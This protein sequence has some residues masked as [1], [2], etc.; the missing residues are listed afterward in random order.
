[1]SRGQH[2]DRRDT[3]TPHPPGE[4]GGSGPMPGGMLGGQREGAG[5]T[6]ATPPPTSA[7]EWPRPQ[8]IA[9]IAELAAVAPILAAA[10]VLALDAEFFQVRARGPDDPTH[11]LSL[12]QIALDQ[13]RVSY[14]VDALRIA[15]LSPLAAPLA[16]GGILKL[17]HGIGADA[18]VLASR[19]LVARD[20]LDLEAVSRSIFGQR[21]SGLQAMLQRASGVRLDKSLQRADW[22]RRPLT[23]AMI[24]Y[25]ARDAE[26]TLV[27][28]AWLAERYPTA[29]ALHRSPAE[30]PPP[31]VAA[32]ILPY[33]EGAR[34]RPVV[35]AVAEAG[36]GADVPAQQRA[37]GAALGAVCHP[38]QRARVMRLITDLEL[39]GLA[40]NLRPY[41]TSAASEERA[42]AARALGRL[43]D[44]A[45][46]ELIAPLL[47][48]PVQDV[49]QA[50]A[51]ALELLHG[52]PPAP[53]PPFRPHTGSLSGPSGPV[54]WTS[55]GTSGDTPDDDGAG[56]RSKL[57]ARFGAT[58]SPPL[59]ADSASEEG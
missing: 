31:A 24:A 20:T 41:L 9:T 19:G 58:S 54:R 22:S 36:L 46:A 43:H 35:L 32:W 13:P 57:R 45:A 37:L 44:T 39:V 21:E 48:D 11:R 18:R 3:G 38:P 14:V 7:P 33:L 59:A 50:A 10:P 4:R 23:A 28:Y 56:W 55:G 8:L 27:L 12:L 49:R 26:M 15:D 40:P 51:L 47:A 1:M 16:D 30:E 5:Y 6:G 34:P 25:A 42:G 2:A 53:R 29:V 17:F 52:A